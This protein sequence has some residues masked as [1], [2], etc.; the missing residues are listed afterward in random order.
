MESN[1]WLKIYRKFLEWEWYD[2]INTKVLFLHILLKANFKD[3]K[4]R[5]VLIKRGSLITSIDSLFN[6]LNRNPHTGKLNKKSQ[7]VSHQNIRTSLKHL[8]STNE[9]T[10]ETTSHYTVITMNN[11]DTYQ[12][13]NKPTNKQLTSD[14]QTT[15]K[16]LTTTIEGYKD[17]KIDIPKG[18]D[19]NIP[20][21]EN[22]VNLLQKALKERYPIPLIGITD[23]KRLY[24]LIQ[25]LSPRKG[26]DEWM[27]VDWKKNFVSFMNTYLESTEEKYYARGVDSLKEKAKLW[28]EYRGKLN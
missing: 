6:E 3:K 15:N 16:Q 14:Q 23:R 1:S 24:N 21:K 4:W 13:T 22:S 11:Y 9:I 20:L 25:V 10:I 28:R 8:I 2:D 12:G 7:Q 27:D 17:I 18:M 5:G 19:T 26:T